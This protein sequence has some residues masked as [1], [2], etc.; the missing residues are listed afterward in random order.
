MCTL[1]LVVLMAHVEGGFELKLGSILAW[2]K[3]FKHLY[4][5][6]Y[7][8]SNCKLAWRRVR[9]TRN[10]VGKWRQTKFVELCFFLAVDC[11]VV[12]GL[13]GLFVFVGRMLWFSVVVVGIVW[14]LRTLMPCIRDMARSGRRARNVR[15]VLK[16]WMPPAPQSEATKLISDT[17]AYR[18]IT[19]IHYCADRTDRTKTP[20]FDVICTS[21]HITNASDSRA[22]RNRS[23]WWGT[24]L[25]WCFGLFVQARKIEKADYRF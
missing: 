22:H 12:L 14:N 15:I 20:T 17:C 11:R 19:H 21:C 4:K 6:I 8:I 23:C 18:V 25:I 5:N 13:F 16:A 3:T 24:R 1:S 9:K 7:M 10:M 2:V